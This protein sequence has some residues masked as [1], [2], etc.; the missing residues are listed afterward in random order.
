MPIPF[1]LEA[2]KNGAE[3]LWHGRPAKFIAHVPEA[4]EMYRVVLLLEN[5]QTA[6]VTEDGKWMSCD[7]VP[8]VT[9]A[10]RTVRTV[11]Y[12]KYAIS[13][14]VLRRVI[15]LQ[16]DSDW[17]PEEVAKQDNFICWIDTE[18]QQDEVEL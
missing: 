3:I 12:R 17:R 8:A 11:R 6:T 2:A 18:W 14:A 15:T 4:H 7:I 13:V 1:D 16:E 9:M 5:G 10:P